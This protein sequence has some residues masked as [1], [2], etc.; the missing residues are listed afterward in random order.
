MKK[1]TLAVAVIILMAGCT[2][3]NVITTNISPTA[4]AAKRSSA[5]TAVTFTQELLHAST[6]GAL[7]GTGH[8]YNFSAGDALR[9]A[10]TRAVEVAYVS[11][12]HEQGRSTNGIF[13]RQISFGL[14]YIDINTTM[15][16]GFFK[17]NFKA[18]CNVSVSV[19]VYDGTG[20]LLAKQSAAGTG[21]S[22][23]TG[24]NINTAGDAFSKSVEK[25]IQ[26][27]ADNCA[28]I[29]VHSAEAAP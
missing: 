16:P 26:Q 17:N 12:T 5:K 7:E 11:A 13:D 1:Y 10:L 8:T 20:R 24:S 4:I 29:L 14:N 21:M 19:E 3:T 6:S 28:N 9:A 25:A 27:L 22:S 15:A 23:Q 18:T 2:H